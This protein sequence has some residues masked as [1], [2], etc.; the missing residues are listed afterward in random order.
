M[1]I[2][3]YQNINSTEYALVYSLDHCNSF[4]VKKSTG[5]IPFSLP[6]V[7]QTVETSGRMITEQTE[8]IH[9]GGVEANVSM[10][11]D[12]G[13][14]NINTL[15]GLVSNKMSKKHKLDIIDWSGQSS[16]Y[17]FIGIIDSV[18]I[19]QEGGDPRLSCNLTFLEGSNSLS[20]MD[21]L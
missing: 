8:F 20:N 21:G 9:I 16:G 1:T 2:N 19:K 14:S 6:I 17:T 5:I 13:M 10:D 12:I 15:L 18:R 11:F 7:D 4:E 3:I